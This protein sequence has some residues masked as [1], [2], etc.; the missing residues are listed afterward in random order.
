[1]EEKRSKRL[2]ALAAIDR[3]KQGGLFPFA[4]GRDG[5]PPPAEFAETTH[6]AS[7][8]P[9]TGEE[10]RRVGAPSVKRPENTPGEEAAHAGSFVMDP[11]G[12]VKEVDQ[13]GVN[14]LRS[15][16]RPLFGLPFSSLVAHQYQEDFSFHLRSVVG[17]G[18]G[19]VCELEMERTD[20][21]SFLAH[22]DSV[23][24]SENGQVSAV[25]SVI[26]DITQ[27]KRAEEALR[28][29][30]ERYKVV[31]EH[32]GDAIA[33]VTTG[34]TLA[35][36]NRRYAQVFGFASKDEPVGL[37]L[38]G[39]IHQDDR[40]RILEVVRKSHRGEHGPIRYEFKGLRKDGSLILV[41]ASEAKI[42]YRGE[43]A[44]VMYLRDITERK[45]AEE[46]RRRL[47]LIVE[48]AP[49]MILVIDSSGVIQYVNTAFLKNNKR[50]Y[51]DVVGAHVLECATGEGDKSF[52]EALW[53]RLQK[54][55]RWTGRITFKRQDN[56]FNEFDVHVSP[57]RN[58]AGEMLN[59]VVTCR[60][61]TA[62]VILE[63]QLRQ[64]HK[65]EA[66][67]TLAGGIAHD[68]NNILAA[69]IGN[70]EL[71]LDDVPPGSS[72]HHNLE[73]VFKASQRAKDLVKQI[74]TFSRRDNQE[75]VLVE[76]GPLVTETMKLLRSSIPATIDIRLHVEP[77]G[78][79]ILADAARLQ[80]I[81][82]NL[83]GNA[84]HAMREKG[85]VLDVVLKEHQVG[86]DGSAPL[87]DLKPG[88][89]LTIV[90]SDTGH[91][92]SENVM[93]RIFDPFFTTKGPGEGTGM[94]L[95]VV[96]GIVKSLKG[97]ITVSSLPG[98]GSTFTVYLPIAASETERTVQEQ[99]LALPGGKERILFVDDETPIA[100][101]NCAI[102][103][104]LGYEVT[105]LSS[106]TEAFEVFASRP[107]AFDLVITDQTMPTLTGAELTKRMRS[108]RK[109]IPVI[110]VT[111][112]SETMDADRARRIGIQQLL[113]KPIIK[114]EL[115]EAIRTAMDGRG[116]GR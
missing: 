88:S 100:E 84:A 55:R 73:Q 38:S 78:E 101:M 3:S 11:R 98:K 12:L 63:Q 16:E 37:P 26:V 46:E 48:Q 34:Q 76:A 69:I 15:K 94:G 42:A 97:A 10:T 7:P 5:P 60:D 25:R 115:A 31:V 104:R 13:A 56:G 83:C 57:M 85:G 74:L 105:A 8:I 65:M 111:G 99:A 50:K 91:G 4:E 39:I 58:S 108:I 18:K 75:A 107:E 72:V 47:S 2:K 24:L 59:Q 17:Q 96:H 22:I 43:P 36:V 89:Y 51:D 68:F 109:D 9:S 54:E 80:Q 66:I 32:A 67:G 95:A 6:A 30:E 27:Q 116:K 77:G 41:E 29:S 90:V 53:A 21:S 64:A 113:L 1:M 79:A 106:S 62:E 49:E 45:R 61:V 112:F 102:L 86:T 110:L 33:I 81:L 52:F 92:M 114:K 82:M 44:I 28:E 70:A 20:G 35:F 23:P 87:P 71:A 103:Q 93:E 19:G 14:L 40:D